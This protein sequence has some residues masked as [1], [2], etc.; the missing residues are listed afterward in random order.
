[1][2]FKQRSL[3]FAGTIL[4]LFLLRGLALQCLTPPLEGADEYQHIAFIQYILE[5]QKLP[6]FGQSNVPKSIYSDLLANPHCKHGW[7]QTSR[8]GCLHYS[9][10]YETSPTPDI[11]NEIFMYQAQHPPLYYLIAAPVYHFVYQ[12]FGFL[13]GVYSL[14]ILN[15]MIGGIGLLFM[16]APLKDVIHDRNLRIATALAATLSP[17]Y[18]VNVSRVA[19]DPLAILLAGISVWLLTHLFRRHYPIRMTFFAGVFVGLGLL[20]KMIALSVFAAGFVF[21]VFLPVWRKN[22][23]L[24]KTFSLTMSFLTGCLLISTPLFLHSISTYGV[25]ILS[26][27]TIG[28]ERSGSTIFDLIRTAANFQS[29]VYFIQFK[30]FG[31][32]LWR[33]GWSSLM[34]N[35]IFFISYA[36]L[37][38]LSFCGAI[39]WFIKA[40][41]NRSKVLSQ[42]NPLLFFCMLIVMATAAAAYSHGVN[43]ILAFGKMITP[44]YYVMIAYPA[45][46][47]CLAFANKAFGTKIAI[48]ILWALI[49]L[50]VITE[51]YSLWFIA[52]PHWSATDSLSK[53]L[54]RLQSVHPAFPSPSWFWV[55][56]SPVMIII[57]LIAHQSFKTGLSPNDKKLSPSEID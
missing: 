5:N 30:L 40:A 1:M 23:S 28:F 44:G 37:L 20:A 32:T 38:F 9:N 41:L 49:A 57:G 53:A 27:E 46:I 39:V 31:G 10:F 18:L 14:R 13:I 17:V 15:I 34:P 42:C 16:L 47:I 48:G 36:C 52:V 12:N 51:L 33:S 29:I 56:Y 6:V 54:Q 35:S 19:N 2:R 43:T 45:F 4:I 50:F 25:L 8:I 26:Q 24:K 21:L 11:S 7:D 22:T 55:L 3:V